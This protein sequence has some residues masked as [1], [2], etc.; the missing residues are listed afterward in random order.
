MLARLFGFGAP[1][2]V[3]HDMTLLWTG[4][5]IEYGFK[6]QKVDGSDA[7][8]ARVMMNVVAGHTTWKGL[9]KLLVETYN[10]RKDQLNGIRLVAWVEQKSLS[11][12]EESGSY[13]VRHPMIINELTDPKIL[14]SYIQNP[15]VD[16]FF[17][18]TTEQRVGI[19][20]TSVFDLDG[21][22]LFETSYNMRPV[23][24]PFTLK[25]KDDV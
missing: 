7:Y 3:V 10:I 19:F 9:C 22:L 24:D 2:D 13:Y 5:E 11:W 18:C 16:F 4:G 25:P 23:I 1:A 6:R 17:K 15:S 8:P 20:E 21:L 14:A 12:S